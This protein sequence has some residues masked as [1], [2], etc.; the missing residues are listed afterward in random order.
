VGRVQ[1]RALGGVSV[2]H[3]SWCFLQPGEPV[4]RYLTAVVR[5]RVALVQGTATALAPDRIAPGEIRAPDGSLLEPGDL[6]PF[7]PRSEAWIRGSA[8]FAP[9][10]AP[11]AQRLL[12]LRAGTPILSKAAPASV[13]V[14][15]F[16]PVSAQHPGRVALLRGT[17]A[18][19]VTLEAGITVSPRMDLHFFHAVPSD[20]LGPAL[21]GDEAIVLEGFFADA[22][23]LET[24]LPRAVAAA[25]IY[26]LARGTTPLGLR[27]DSIGIDLDRR[28]ARLVFRGN[29]ELQPADDP[30]R[31]GLVAGLELGM[32]LAF[33]ATF[34]GAP[35]PARDLSST[36]AADVSEILARFGASSAATAVPDPGA[37]ASQLPFRA[38]PAE[39][40][41]PEPPRPRDDFGGTLQALGPIAP[42]T[43]FVQAPGETVGFD[44]ERMGAIVRDAVAALPFSRDSTPSPVPAPAAW[45]ARSGEDTLTAH[46][47]MRAS[48]VPTPAPAVARTT[49]IPT[50]PAAHTSPVLSPAPPPPPVEAIGSA[51]IGLDGISIA[52]LLERPSSLPFSPDAPPTEAPE[53]ERKSVDAIGGMTLGLDGSVS[54]DDLLRPA[55]P[56]T[57]PAHLGARRLVLLPK[58]ERPTKKLSLFFLDALGSSQA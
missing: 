30:E 35:A 15:A 9:G 42:P 26:G 31:M 17:P 45:P 8:T 49:P 48:P 14:T 4:R 28:T 20:Q 56:F 38:G 19:S 32:P 13:R 36:T 33:P 57:P 47:A 11:R 27:L 6:V 52:A 41:P 39:L 51:T 2:G 29:L 18:R 54:I 55:M 23:R 16:E 44:A 34:D 1:A 21:V 43:P 53:P 12:L 5:A 10:A 22:P 7:L 40:P 24:R 3:V 46:L 37:R 25:R 58:S 50:P